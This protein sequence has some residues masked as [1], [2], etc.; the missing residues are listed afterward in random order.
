MMTL[1][2]KS[3]GSKLFVLKAIQYILALTHPQLHIREMRCGLSEV[4]SFRLNQ[5]VH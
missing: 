3:I 2:Q 4:T 1:K 5:A